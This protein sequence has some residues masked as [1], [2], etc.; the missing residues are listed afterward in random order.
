[1]LSITWYNQAI[2]VV[3]EIVSAANFNHF[4][5]VTEFFKRSHVFGKGSL[6]CQDTNFNTFHLSFVA[7]LFSRNDL[8]DVIAIQFAIWILLDLGIFQR[9]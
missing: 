1:M 5:F 3:G 7:C 4:N 2:D 8:I 6:D 9:V